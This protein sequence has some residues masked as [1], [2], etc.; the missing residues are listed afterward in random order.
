MWPQEVAV[1]GRLGYYRSLSST[2][3]AAIVVDA[4]VL[5]T[6]GRTNCATP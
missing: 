2:R 5:V 1:L 3:P 4:S 6:A